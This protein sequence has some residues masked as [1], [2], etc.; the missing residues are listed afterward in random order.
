MNRLLRKLIDHFKGPP[1]RK[2]YFDE[3]LDQEQWDLL[4]AAAQLQVTE[5]KLFELAYRDWYGHPARQQAI[6]VC[7]RNYMFNRIIPIGPIIDWD[8]PHG[9]DEVFPVAKSA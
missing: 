2:Q 8:A 6:E 4:E 9:R 7:F 1:G 3:D 5:F